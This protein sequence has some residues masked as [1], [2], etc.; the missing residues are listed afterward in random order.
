[1]ERDIPSYASG[2][3]A[4]RLRDVLAL[5]R[6]SPT[7]GGYAIAGR[8]GNAAVVSSVAASLRLRAWGELPAVKQVKLR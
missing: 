6:R 3:I 8:R 2:E 1:M 5:G 7:A 4:S